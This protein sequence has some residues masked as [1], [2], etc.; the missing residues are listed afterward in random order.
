[1][2][3]RRRT[4]RQCV[5]G[6]NDQ[7]SIF[8]KTG[9]ELGREREKDFFESML[10]DLREAVKSVNA[11]P[12]DITYKKCIGY[13]SLNFRSSNICRLK[14][15]GKKWYISIPITLKESIPNTVKTSGI[16]SEP[17]FL[18]I[19]FSQL[20]KDEIVHL[21]KEAALLSV[22]KVSKEFDC[23][24]RFMACSDAKV[25]VHPDP[26][27]SLLCGYRKILKN[28]RIFYGENRNVK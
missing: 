12:E 10:P 18:R 19:H 6:M 21:L 8:P 7:L 4:M 3:P 17:Q 24:S 25:C 27:F 26:S 15:R 20:S 23:C 9:Q 14:L 13:S 1:M 5:D 22:E 2:Y 28:G 11:N 16:A